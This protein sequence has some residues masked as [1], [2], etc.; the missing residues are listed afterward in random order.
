[1]AL[2]SFNYFKLSIIDM[3]PAFQQPIS[4]VPYLT[5]SIFLYQFHNVPKATGSKILLS[6]SLNCLCSS[7]CLRVR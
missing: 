3:F 4:I 5:A 6:V 1:M 7:L 2:L